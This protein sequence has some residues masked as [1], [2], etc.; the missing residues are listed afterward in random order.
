M[1]NKA[2]EMKLTPT[3]QK[4]LT[5]LSKGPL[6]PS[7]IGEALSTRRHL[8]AQGAGRLGGGVAARLIKMGFARHSDAR[9]GF[10]CYEITEAGR[11]ALVATGEER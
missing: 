2:S 6:A 10:P 5:L 9:G 8:K 7:S 3:Q 11:Q 1:V 4:T